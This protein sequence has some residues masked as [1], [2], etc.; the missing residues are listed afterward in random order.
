MNKVEFF[1]AGEELPV[2]LDFLWLII[3]GVVESYTVNRTGKVII[4]GFWGKQ[5]VIG[6]SLSKIDPY[7]L[8]CLSEVRAIA[9]ASDR[10]NTIS[11]NLLNR[12]QQL[13]EISYIVRNPPEDRL[14]LLLQWLAQKFGNQTSLGLEISFEL[15]PQ[16]L[17]DSLGMTTTIVNRILNQL[18]RE[19]RIMRS[20]ERYIVLN[21]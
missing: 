15:T 17:A 3:D 4:L 6:K 1:D 21:Q 9:V 12:I 11:V 18:E 14:W 5:E 20:N 8:K 10:W 2:A 7:F 16:E 13:Q 19:N